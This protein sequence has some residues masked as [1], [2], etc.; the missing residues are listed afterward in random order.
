VYGSL[1]LVCALAPVRDDD[2][3]TADIHLTE[4][5]SAALRFGAGGNHVWTAFGPTNVAIHRVATAME[6]QTFRQVAYARRC[7]WGRDI[8]STD[9][10]VMPCRASSRR[11]RSRFSAVLVALPST[12]VA[13]SGTPFSTAYSR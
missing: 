4:A 5:D 11:D 3:G 2:R 8:S 9:L 13:S 10:T 6:R 7:W 12:R 1:H